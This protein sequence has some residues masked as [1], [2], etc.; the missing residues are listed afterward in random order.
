[1]KRCRAR[2]DKNQQETRKPRGTLQFFSTPQVEAETKRSE[3]TV[4]S[5][6][7]LIKALEHNFPIKS[8]SHFFDIFPFSNEKNYDFVL[9]QIAMIP[10]EN[11][12]KKAI[13]LFGN[14]NVQSMLPEF[15]PRANLIILADIDWRV[16]QHNLHVLAC[17]K[18]SKSRDNFFQNYHCNNP[19][20]GLPCAKNTV[21][22]PEVLNGAYLESLFL[23]SAN[24]MKQY[25]CLSSDKRFLKCQ[26]AL[27]EM[28]IVNIH[29][30]LRNKQS[31]YKLFQILQ[32]YDR[33][34]FLC[35]FTNIHHYDD[36]SELN[37]SVPSLLKQANKSW[38]MY[39]NWEDKDLATKLSLGLKKYCNECLK[40]DPECQLSFLAKRSLI[41]RP[42]PVGLDA[43][44][45]ATKTDMDMLF[46]F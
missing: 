41:S 32:R 23:G 2:R 17:L 35:N 46:G 22:D 44:L 5:N 34:F 36:R 29:L 16:H 6:I 30:D 14:S 8:D 38:V 13:L 26:K 18:K 1:M 37:E 43:L 40:I 7:S 3:A 12:H 31:C 15:L 4:D 28:Y 21:D 24:N 20:E 27:K 9:E 11:P 10:A 39:S 42:Q 45:A 19:I 33:E 25:S